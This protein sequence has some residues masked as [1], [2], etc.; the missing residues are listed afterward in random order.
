MAWRKTVVSF[1]E[2]HGFTRSL[3]EPCWWIR[4]GPNGSV[5]NMVLLEVD[6]FFIGSTATEDRKWLRDRLESR[7]K[8]G[9]Y[10]DCGAGPVDFAGRRITI[11]PKRAAVDMEKYILEEMR[12]LSVAR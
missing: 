3:L 6:D 12:P 7:F 5:R 4:Y 2:R 11:G 8:F 10:R 1:L 9:K